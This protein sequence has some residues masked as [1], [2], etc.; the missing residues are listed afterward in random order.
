MKN[1]KTKLIAGSLALLAASTSASAEF[2]DNVQVTQLGAYEAMTLHYV[3]LSSGTSAEC[4]ASS[5]NPVLFFNDAQP[6]GKG[7]LTMLISAVVN[8]RNVSVR[9]QGCNI[10]EIYLK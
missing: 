5:G 6:G 3:W 7:M 9:T 2:I 8:K 1:I 10:T 4:A